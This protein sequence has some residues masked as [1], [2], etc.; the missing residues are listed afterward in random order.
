MKLTAIAVPAVTLALGSLFASAAIADQAQ[1]ESP[2]LK[3]QVDESTGNL[4]K[5]S[6]SEAAELESATQRQLTQDWWNRTVPDTTGT[7]VIQLGNGAKAA[8]MSPDSLE[9]LS[10]QIDEDGNVVA[11]HTAIDAETVEVSTTAEETRDEE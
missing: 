8:R 1:E 6:R 11:G 5:A 4:R 2:S 7:E 9:A 10:I 3:I